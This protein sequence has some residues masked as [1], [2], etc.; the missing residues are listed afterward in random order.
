M[1][2]ACPFVAMSVTDSHSNLS[3]HSS[4]CSINEILSCPQPCI[5]G[6]LWPFDSRRMLSLLH[7]TMLAGHVG[8]SNVFMS[9]SLPPYHLWIDA[10]W[11]GY[12]S[13]YLGMVGMFRSDD[14]CF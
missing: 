2:A 4:I 13:A 10:F 8:C 12:S 3:Q 14:P 7:S 6:F 9:R 5:T 11:G 1:R